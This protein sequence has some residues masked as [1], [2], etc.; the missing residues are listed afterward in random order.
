[1]TATNQP[2]TRRRLKQT[3]SHPLHTMQLEAAQVALLTRY[4]PE[5]RLRRVAW[6][7]GETQVMELGSGPPLLLVHGGLASGFYWVPI[8]PALA[9]NHHVFVVDLPGHGLADPFDYSSVDIFGHARTFLR[10]I[11]N[12]L[13]LGASDIVANSLGGLWLGAFT[14]DAPERVSRLA[15]V[16]APAGVTHTIP[17]SIRI[18][19][20]PLIGQPLG[21]RL[22]SDH[23]REGNRK[24]WG[25][26]LVVHPEYLDDTLLDAHIA[27]V[28]RN[29]GS[30]LS[31]VC[32]I[33]NVRGLRRHLILGRHWRELRVPTLL[34]CGERDA[35]ISPR[36]WALWDAIASQNPSLGIVP[37]PD[38]GHFPWMDD[39]ERTVGAIE[40]FLL[41]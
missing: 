16:G 25:Q 40:R 31:L 3:L 37:I 21:Q 34:I 41:A 1:M 9:R 23:T 32:R 24:F 15:L 38:A 10:D 28:Q 19:A 20:L 4:A 17:F 13:E 26:V 8:L 22:L 39:A 14:L 35:F 2:T 29:I 5:T 36:G 30:M 7:Q 12:A 11:L 6:S 33:A 27:H 18:P